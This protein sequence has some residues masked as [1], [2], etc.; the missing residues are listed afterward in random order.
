MTPDQLRTICPKLGERAE[1]WVTP[2]NDVMQAGFI[3]SPKRQAAFIA[4][5]AHESGQFLHLIENLNY[6]AEALLRTFPK[7]FDTVAALNFARQ[8]EQIANKI[9]GG[10]MGNTEP[11]DGWKFRGRGIF[12]HTGKNNYAHLSLSMFGDGRLLED[13]DLLMVPENACE[14]ARVYWQ[15]NNLNNL[16]DTDF[17]AVCDVVNIGRQTAKVGD[18]NGY[19][20]RLAYYQ[21]ALT[22]LGSE[23]TAM[24]M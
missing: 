19:A 7:Y 22:V 24:R 2:L 8:P 12:Q 18:S 13:P 21:R 15:D 10:R 17:D 5:C 1:V 23:E 11:G 3:D 9:Y 20:D 14:G 16:A 6:S 4:Q